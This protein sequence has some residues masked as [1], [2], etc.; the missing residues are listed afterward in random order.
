MGE[1]YFENNHDF[2]D[3]VTRIFLFILFVFT[4]FLEIYNYCKES[5]T[6]TDIESYAILRKV[7]FTQTELDLIL[8]C[9][10]WANGKIQE[11]RDSKE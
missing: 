8:K 1:E 2:D 4:S 3:C 10:S 5:I 11:M 6:W 9:M 7:E